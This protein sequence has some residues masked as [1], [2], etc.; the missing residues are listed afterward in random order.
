M[1]WTHLICVRGSN[2]ASVCGSS[3]VAWVG[4][5]GGV[6]CLCLVSQSSPHH[7]FAVPV[8]S[9]DGGRSGWSI[10]AVCDCCK[11]LGVASYVYVN[12]SAL[13]CE[14]AARTCSVHV[15]AAF[16]PRVSA[17]APTSRAGLP[18][19]HP[20]CL[21]RDGLLAGAP[22]R[23]PGPPGPDASS[24]VSVPMLV[25]LEAAMR[26]PWAM[27]QIQ[28]H[29]SRRHS[30]RGTPSASGASATSPVVYGCH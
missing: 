8:S 16:V 14:R 11:W 4:Y 2:T 22:Q 12:P 17:V 9:W 26:N 24:F 1:H 5:G 18:P 19:G 13:P 23:R 10:L 21:E 25:P 20:A 27:G 6:W 29:S 3:V 7:H 15:G 28:P 30:L